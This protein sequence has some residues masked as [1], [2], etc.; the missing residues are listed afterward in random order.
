[1]GLVKT[2]A[3]STCGVEGDEGG[4]ESNP[5]PESDPGA[6]SG[7]DGD[8]GDADGSGGEGESDPEPEGMDE[9]PIKNGN[10]PPFWL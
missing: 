4:A 3:S 8:E 6:E 2:H 9:W 10:N 7:G 1:M 5:E